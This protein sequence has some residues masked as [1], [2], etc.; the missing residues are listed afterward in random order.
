M[1]ATATITIHPL[2]MITKNNDIT[3][4]CDNISVNHAT[5][6]LM[7]AGRDTVELAKRYGTPLYLIDED[8]IRAMCRIYVNAMKEAFDEYSKPLFASKA[9]CF[10]KIYNIVE[11]EGVG[12]DVASVG[13]LF[14]ALRA[15]F[16]PENIIFHGNNK[17]DDDIEFAIGQKVGCFVCDN[18]EELEIIDKYAASLNVKQKILLRITPG[19]DPHTHA[20]INT[21]RVDSKFGA[22]IETLQAEELTM[23]ALSLKN[24]EL[25][26]FHCHIGSQIFDYE[27]FADAAKIMIGFIA[28]IKEKTGSTARY[29]NLGGGMG[30][31]Y[32]ES[33]PIIDYRSNIL[34]IGKIIKEECKA[35]NITPPHIFME[36]GRSIVADAGMTLYTVGTVKRIPGYKNYVS[37][38]GGMADNPRFALYGSPYTVVMANKMTDGGES[39][40]AT[41]AGRCCESG[42]IIQEGVTLPENTTRGDTLAVLTTGAYNYSMASNYNRLPKPPMVMLE[43]GS[44]RIVIK[45]ESFEDVA[46]YDV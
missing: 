6:H 5:G 42:D 29:L 36:P 40:V 2:K 12:T 34:S 38:D 15:D 13:E 7:F 26:G 44:D 31:R 1:T 35:H 10:K 45:G 9:L 24:I 17:T 11:S 41:V 23:L 30:V 32:V 27:P 19:I 14:T 46:R 28:D 39:F 8:H 18:R 43:G 4:L 22:A 3:T 37:V 21:G 16:P 33:D 25:R 20:K